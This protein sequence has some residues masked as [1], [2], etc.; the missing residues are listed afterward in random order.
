MNTREAFQQMSAATKESTRGRGGLGAGSLMRRIR[1]SNAG[2]KTPRAEPLRSCAQLAIHLG[3]QQGDVQRVRHRV[4]DPRGLARSPRPQEKEAP[5]GRGGSAAP[6]RTF[7]RSGGAR[8]LGPPL[9]ACFQSSSGRTPTT[10]RRRF[11]VEVAS[12]AEAMLAQGR[13]IKARRFLAL[14]YWQHKSQSRGQTAHR[15]GFTIVSA[16]NLEKSR[17]PVIKARTPCSKHSAAI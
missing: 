4:T 10:S 8:P 12:A 7:A 13:C 3:A 16:G 1:L 11:P 15:K 14:F 17:S 9:P 5:P 6:R 2:N